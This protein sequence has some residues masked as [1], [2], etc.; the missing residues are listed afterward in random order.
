MGA[1]CRRL[2]SRWRPQDLD[3]A[4]TSALLGA[5]SAIIPPG[6]V[7]CVT[8]D[9][10]AVSSS[11]VPGFLARTALLRTLIRLIIFR[12]V[13]MLPHISRAVTLNSLLMD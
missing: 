11:R 7:H 1:D 6:I 2:I 4:D 9:E 8:V 10:C 3:A 12:L 5:R 13:V